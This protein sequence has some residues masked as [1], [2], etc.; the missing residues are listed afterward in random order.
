MGIC[1]GEAIE[2]ESIEVEALGRVSSGVSCGDMCR[3]GYRSRSYRSSSMSLPEADTGGR[4][5]GYV[6]ARL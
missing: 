3:R 6:Q 2:V 4:L 5:W 1:A